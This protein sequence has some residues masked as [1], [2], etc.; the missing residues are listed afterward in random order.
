MN[1]S[2]WQI[3]N[4]KMT[5]KWQ[6]TNVLVKDD[7][8]HSVTWTWAFLFKVTDDNFKSQTL[9]VTADRYTLF[10]KMLSDKWPS[11]IVILHCIFKTVISD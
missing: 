8:C 2:D 3:T 11:H 10:F 9:R 4:G 1:K 6:I 7:K 5:S